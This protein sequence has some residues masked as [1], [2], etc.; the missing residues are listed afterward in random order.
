MFGYNLG[1]FNNSNLSSSIG[2]T[3]C[4]ASEWS[5]DSHMLCTAP[6]GVGMLLSSSVNLLGRTSTLTLAFSYTRRLSAVSLRQSE[7][8]QAVLLLRFLD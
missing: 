6:S 3:G 2:V 4:F 1:T 5:S 7:P 8:P